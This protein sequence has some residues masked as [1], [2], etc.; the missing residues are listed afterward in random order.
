MYST[1]GSAATACINVVAAAGSSLRLARMTSAPVAIR[2]TC[3][4]VTPVLAAARSSTDC[5]W[6][7]SRWAGVPSRNCTMN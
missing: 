7:M 5:I 1:A 3:T 6:A 2:R 4:S